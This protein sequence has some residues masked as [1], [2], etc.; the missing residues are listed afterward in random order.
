MRDTASGAAARSATDWSAHDAPSMWRMLAPQETEAHWRHVAGLRKLTEL[1]ATHMARLQV[2]RD[3]L[4]EAWPP[5]K[6]PAAHAFIARLDYL[7]GHV[8]ATH[9]VAATN[10]SALSTATLT[11]DSARTK[12]ASINAEYA[13]KFQTLKDYDALVEST[14]VSQVPG[15]SLGPPPVAA[16]DLERLNAKA[17]TV[18]ADLSHTLVL[19]QIQFRRPTP[20]ESSAPREDPAF[21]PRPILSTAPI[22]VLESPPRTAASA[23]VQRPQGSMS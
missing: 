12:V 2:Y 13:A 20:Y 11:L 15:T 6:S 22:T 3:H 23:V 9:E 7:I 18:M 21:P 16:A 8:R 17:R 5:E 4:A 1:T 10:Y 19:A 14:K